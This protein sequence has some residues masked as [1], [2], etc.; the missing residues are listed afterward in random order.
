MH[1]G[2]ADHGKKHSD[3]HYIHLAAMSAVSFVVMYLLMYSMVD[4]LSNIF[5]SWNQVYMAGMMTASMIFIELVF[6]GSMYPDKKK[7][8][9][10]LVLSFCV[11]LL[12]FFFTRNQTGITDKQF[13][14]SMIPH[15]AGALLMCEQT[16]AENLKIAE[17]CKEIK[18]GQTAEIELMKS[19]LSELN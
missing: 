16:K 6:M 19:L 13:L 17:L 14:R 11:T 1:K 12:F 5:H 18:S 8:K 4:S 15:H 2:H 10:L 7:N 9:F 3:M